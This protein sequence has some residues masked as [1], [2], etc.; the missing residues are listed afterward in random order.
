MQLLQGMLGSWVY[1]PVVLQFIITLGIV[2]TS[3]GMNKYVWTI[4]KSILLIRTYINWT[5]NL[6][7]I[8]LFTPNSICLLTTFQWLYI[9]IEG[10]TYLAL[11][12]EAGIIL[13]GQ[14]TCSTFS[15]PLTT[16]ISTKNTFKMYPRF[17]LKASE[18]EQLYQV[19]PY[20]SS[21]ISCLCIY[22]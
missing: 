4:I 21:F 6:L 17:N 19:W 13:A 22:I 7:P 5:M 16:L 12:S 1:T 20:M 2:Q 14:I 3:I 9:M 11:R 8:F 15:L 10:W 18:R